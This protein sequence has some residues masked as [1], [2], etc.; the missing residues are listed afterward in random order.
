MIAK[1]VRNAGIYT[2]EGSSPS[3]GR[4]RGPSAFSPGGHGDPERHDRGRGAGGG[5]PFVPFRPGDRRG[6]RL[7]GPVRHPRFRGP[8]YPHVLCPEAGGGVFP[9]PRGDALP[10]DPPEGRGILSS[11]RSGREASDDDL[12]EN[13]LVLALSA[14]SMGTTTVEMKSGYGLDTETELRMLSVIRRVGR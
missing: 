3:A 10:G 5:D 4:T 9:P 11:V 8:P 13:T 14:L 7:R 6:D 2:P 12:F 1:L